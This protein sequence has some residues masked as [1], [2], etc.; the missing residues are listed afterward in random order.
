AERHVAEDHDR[1]RRTDRT[2]AVHRRTVR[3][4]DRRTGPARRGRPA[5]VRP[6][7]R[8]RLQWREIR[9]FLDRPRG[10]ARGTARRAERRCRG[11]A[12]AM[13]GRRRP[14]V[15]IPTPQAAAGTKLTVQAWFNLILAIMTLLVI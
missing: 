11:P 9:R 7:T 10:G 5:R 15:T 2:G 4:E 1:D 3:G 8:K 13:G 6:R 12:R 14:L